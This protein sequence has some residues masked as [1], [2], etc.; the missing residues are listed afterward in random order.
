MFDDLIVTRKISQPVL[1]EVGML[2]I[3]LKANPTPR[4]HL[5]YDIIN[6][7]LYDHSDISLANLWLDL[8][9]SKISI[10]H[11]R[12]MKYKTYQGFVVYPYHDPLER[13]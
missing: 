7:M 5:G 6:R 9:L 4:L 13:R 2:I 11:T 10:I 1:L 12:V 8:S 3:Y